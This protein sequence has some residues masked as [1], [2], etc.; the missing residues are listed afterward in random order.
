MSSL[1][2]TAYP[3]FKP[4]LTDRELK[5]VYS[6]TRA[7]ITFAQRQARQVSARLGLLVQLKTVQRLGYFV[8]IGDVPDVIVRHIAS[9]IS[10]RSLP[11]GWAKRYDQSGTRQ[12]HMTAIRNRLAIRPFM[13]GGEA[14]VTSVAERAADTK[15][16]LPDIINE[17]IEELV[18]QRYELPA[19]QT[20]ARAARAARNQV[21]N[22]CYETLYRAVTPAGKTLINDLLGVPA[23]NKPSGWQLLK[24]EPKQPRHKAIK[25]F[26]AHQSWLASLAAEMPDV[27]LISVSRR[28]QYLLEARALHVNEVRE[29]KMHKRFALAVILIH[30]QHQQALDDIADIFRRKLQNLHSTAELRLQQYHLEHVRRTEALVGRFRDVLTAIHSADSNASRL[31][32]IEQI[33]GVDSDKWLAE[34]EEFMAYADNSYMPFMLTS[35]AQWRPLFYRCLDSLTIQSASQDQSL[36]KALQFLMQYRTSHREWLPVVDEHGRELLNLQWLPERWRKWVTGQTRKAAVTAVHRKYFELCVFTQIAQELNNCDLFV[37]GSDKYAD[38]REQLVDWTEYEATVDEY[39]NMLGFKTSARHFV[40]DLKRQLTTLAREVDERFPDNEYLEMG[41]RGLVV[42]KHVTEEPSPEI[43]ELD[44][45]IRERL[46]EASILDVLVESEGWLDLHKT[47]GPITGFEA[48]LKDRRE[49]F[50]S[51][52]FCYGCNLGPSQTARS[53]QGYS[54]KQLAWLN[55]RH[56]TEEKLEQAIVRVIN[57]YNQFQLPKFW[58]DGKHASADGTKWNVYEQNLLSEYHI[59]YGGYGGIGYYHVSDQY[60]ALFSHFI[61]CGVYEAVY[62]LDGLIK[63]TSDIQPDTIHGDTQAQSGPVFG[64]AYLLGINLMP[65]MRGIKK[66]IFYRPDKKTRYKH[67][68]GLFSETINWSLIEN[69]LPDMLRV[70]LSIKAGKISPS[71]IL[72]RLGTHSRKNKLYFAFRE[73]G[74]AIRTMFLLRYVNEVELRKVV[75]SATNKSEEFNQFS[76]WLFFGND[77]IIAENVRHEQRKIIK[78]NQ[79]V[80]NMVILHNVEA[81]S[82]VIQELVQEG[83][84]ITPKMLAGLGPYRTFHINRLGRYLLNLDRKVRPPRY[85]ATLI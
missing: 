31:R 29:L 75:H 51:T 13:D 28:H 11:R 12:R 54:R 64:L 23:R 37:V 32:A 73:L 80:A 27:A 33:V 69:H 74:R 84:N 63:N 40:S 43:V 58:G 26:L 53:V 20:L 38:Y 8:F 34:C 70:A 30:A 9:F 50:I 14:V 22:R 66:L 81:M 55:L 4:E 60:I 47:F 18:R 7:E 25:Q 2:E 15:Q 49:R 45:V 1:H 59:R 68:N 76:Q 57:A 77:S 42:H 78:Y 48:K 17:V 79:L 52:L 61:P 24:L 5:E 62:I 16:E 19:F 83:Q 35:Y 56:I 39:T 3:R 46:P 44:H 72:R 67:I 85:N 41:P 21:N 82:S 36:V 65:R 71:T 10:K 6:P